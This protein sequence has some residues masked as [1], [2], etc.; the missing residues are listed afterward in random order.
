MSLLL[1]ISIHCESTEQYNHFTILSPHLFQRV[2]PFVDF[3]Q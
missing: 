3:E 1:G 2:M